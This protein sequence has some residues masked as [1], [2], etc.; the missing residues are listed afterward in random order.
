MAEAVLRDA[1]G[2]EQVRVWREILDRRQ[3]NGQRVGASLWQR[4]RLF[5]AAKM[6]LFRRAYV[7]T[8]VRLWKCTGL[9]RKK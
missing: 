2:T 5:F 9:P 7:Q 1:T 3:K 8:T 4:V 6:K